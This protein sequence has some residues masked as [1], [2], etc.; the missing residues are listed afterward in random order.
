[1][2]DN[3]EGMNADY[4][5]SLE[6]NDLPFAITNNKALEVETDLDPET[7]NVVVIVTD[8]GDTP[9]SSSTTVQVQVE[10]S[11]MHNPMFGES[12]YTFTFSETA[13]GV[14]A[15]FTFTI[16][17]SDEGGINTPGTAD[18]RIVPS[19]Y[20]DRF[21]ISSTVSGG[22][23]EAKLTVVEPFDR[24]SIETTFITVEAFDTGYVDFRRTSKINITI[25]ISDENDNFPVFE[26][27]H[28]SAVV[29]ENASVGHQFFQLLASD[30][31][32]DLD[33]VLSY[34]LDNYNDVFS[35]GV[36]TGWL[37]VNG[38]LN[39][40]EQD[41]YVLNVRV[42]DSAGQSDNATVNVTVAEVN[43]FAPQF[44]GVPS[45]V[46]IQENTDYSL[47]F[48]VYDDDSDLPGEFTVSIEHSTNIKYFVLEDDNVLRLQYQLDYEVRVRG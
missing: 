20:S 4:T 42:T 22:E 10:P 24:E 7:Y 29:G 27:D 47:N 2:S 44:V 21:N 8:H 34:T 46:L 12:E 40:Q 48:S 25:V 37:S 23:T 32:T 11:N 33:F 43:E 16:T 35:V 41:K 39:R 3:D 1:M 45:A 6:N 5:L 14:G 19:D 30:E 38:P 31:D 9:L 36:S 18:V 15:E 13:V 26:E 17:D 28:F